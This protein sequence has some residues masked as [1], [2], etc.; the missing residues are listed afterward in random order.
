MRRG[1]A[2]AAALLAIVVGAGPVAAGP[3]LADDDV[4]IGVVI[5]EPEALSVADAQLRWGINTESG[6]GA[7]FGGCNF[8]SAG[9]AGSTGGSRAWTA[10]DGFYAA[11][12]GQ[13]RIEK[14]TAD[15][16]REAASWATRCL[17]PDG[18]PVSVGSIDS[19]SHNEVV[20][21][22]G[23]GTV[24]PA[25]GT[26]AIRWTGSFTVAFYGGMTYWTATDPVLEVADGA[27]TLSATLS[28]YGA[29]RSDPGRWVRLAPRSVV[30]ADLDGVQVEQG[31][32]VVLPEYLGV[33]VQA[34]AGAGVQVARDET[35]AD[36]WGAFPQT[37]VDFQDEVGQAAYWYSSGGA[38]DRA[39][40]AVALVVSFDA[41][42][43]VDPPDEDDSSTPPPAPSAP[44]VVPPTNSVN[45]PPVRPAPATV[46][47]VT[48]GSGGDAV[49]T[50]AVAQVPP[51]SG[52]Q[53]LAAQQV[54][55]AAADGRPLVDDPLAVG[56]LATIVVLLGAGAWGL[57]RGWVVLPWVR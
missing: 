11:R 56:A 44:A 57:R 49:V 29:D 40:P 22:G 20:V 4:E 8:L 31:G 25:S 48:T 21:D 43:P 55:G 14:P 32:L 18:N 2:L 38:R 42:A 47:D 3:A 9:A 30:L 52:V 19:A 15:G 35:N 46:T 39:K 26:A 7:Y 53:V 37:M 6:A 54:T 16:T 24:D 13:V 45:P 10:E 17:D 12:A 1:A 50:P 5:P 34:P 23:V 36:W 51:G 33:S 28:G 27:G 41:S